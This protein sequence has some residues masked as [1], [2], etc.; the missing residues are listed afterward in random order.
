MIELAVTDEG[1]EQSLALVLDMLEA[2][3]QSKTGEVR[4]ALLR[5][6]ALLALDVARGGE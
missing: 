5:A 3:E 6:S 2:A 4:E 1:R